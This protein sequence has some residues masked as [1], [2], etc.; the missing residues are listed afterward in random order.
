MSKIKEEQLTKLQQLLNA[1]AGLSNTIVGLSLQKNM[2]IQQLSDVKSQLQK[3][4]ESLSKE[5]GSDVSINPS[6]GQITKVPSPT[7]KGKLEVAG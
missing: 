3:M 2:A 6:T 4:R 7:Q 5:Y 1:E